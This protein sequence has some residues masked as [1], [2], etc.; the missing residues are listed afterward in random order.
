[1]GLQEEFDKLYDFTNDIDDELSEV[2]TAW[3]LVVDGEAAVLAALPQEDWQAHLDAI[4]YTY[5]DDH[6]PGGL[7]AEAEAAWYERC[8]NVRDKALRA[9]RRGATEIVQAA[10]DKAMH[11]A[12]ANALLQSAKAAYLS[13]DT[14]EPGWVLEL[15]VGVWHGIQAGGAAAFAAGADRTLFNAGKDFL[16]ANAARAL[17]IVDLARESW[18]SDAVGLSEYRAAREALVAF[19]GP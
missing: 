19:V 5:A 7:S 17:E 6:K 1:M 8:A 13:G 16:V 11:V 15:V 3:T 14:W 4:S 10:G 18:P 2:E 12:K 9:I